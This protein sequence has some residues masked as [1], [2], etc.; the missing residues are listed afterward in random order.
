MLEELERRNYAA[1]TTRAYLRAVAEFA[2]Y[3]HRSPD[4]L[5]AGSHPPIP[6]LSVP[7]KEV[8]AQHRYPASLRNPFLLHPVC[9]D[10]LPYGCRHAGPLLCMRTRSLWGKSG[11]RRCASGY[12]E[13]PDGW[14]APQAAPMFAHR[15]LK[16]SW[17]ADLTPY[18]KKVLHLPSIL[19][20]EE[21]NSLIEAAPPPFQRT[22][23]MA[24]Y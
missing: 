7:R 20:R 3:F 16:Q 14:F 13:D 21:V 4:Q 15:T 5:G 18:P 23:L 6:R 8:P 17:S 9:G 19:S 2:R 10:A 22:L 11:D 12:Q 1:S 24:L